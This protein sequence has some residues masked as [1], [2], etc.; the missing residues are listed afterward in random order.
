M[1]KEYDFDL[2]RIVCRSYD[3]ICK[4]LDE[5]LPWRDIYSFLK[6]DHELWRSEWSIDD[7]KIYFRVVDD[8]RRGK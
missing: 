5:G 7:V 8:E 3:S 1:L 4:S 2:F 6:V